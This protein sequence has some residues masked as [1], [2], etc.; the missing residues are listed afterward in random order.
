MQVRA[1]QHHHQQQ[2]HQQQQQQLFQ[3]PLQQLQHQHHSQQLQTHNQHHQQLGFPAAAAAAAAASDPPPPLLQ[4]LANPAPTSPGQLQVA[5]VLPMHDGIVT[6]PG[7]NSQPSQA[8]SDAGADAGTSVGRVT[9]AV[10]PSGVQHGRACM[11]A[12][13]SLL[14]ARQPPPP[15]TAGAAPASLHA[16]LPASGHAPAVC[17]TALPAG[18]QHLPPASLSTVVTVAAGGPVESDGVRVVQAG[19]KPVRVPGSRE[20]QLGPYHDLASM[21]GPRKVSGQ[22]RRFFEPTMVVVFDEG[23]RLADGRIYVPLPFISKNFEGEAFP[24]LLNA[25]VLMDGAV[26]KQEYQV[27]IARSQN[28][29]RRHGL[30]NHW[31]TGHQRLIKNYKDVRLMKMELLSAKGPLVLELVSSGLWEEGGAGRAQLSAAAAAA[32]S[33]AALAASL[34]QGSTHHHHHQQQQQ[35]QHLQQHQQQPLQQHLHLQ[36]QQHHQLQHQIQLHLQQQQQIYASPSGL[37]LNSFMQVTNPAT[38]GGGP[39]SAAALHNLSVQLATGLGHPG[40]NLGSDVMMSLSLNSSEAPHGSLGFQQQYTGLLDSYGMAQQQQQRQQLLLMA[41]LR[42]ADTPAPS[43]PIPTSQLS[44]SLAAPS[45]SLELLAGPSPGVHSSG[46]PHPDAAPCPQLF[47]PLTSFTDALTRTAAMTAP[48]QLPPTHAGSDPCA[49]TLVEHPQQPQQQHVQQQ[50][51]QQ[52]QHVQ[53]PQQQQQQHVQQQ[54]QQQQQQQQPQH[55]T[56]LGAAPHTLTSESLPAAAEQVATPWPPSSSH[57]AAGAPHAAAT[58]EVHTQQKQAPPQ[59]L[60]HLHQQLE[61]LRQQQQQQQHQQQQQ[62]QHHQQQQAQQQHHQ[63]QQAQQQHHQQQTQQQQQQLSY[64]MLPSHNMNPTNHVLQPQGGILPPLS[65]AAPPACLYGSPWSAPSLPGHSSTTA[66]ATL[67]PNNSCGQ[68]GEMQPSPFGAGNTLQSELHVTLGRMTE[69]Q[70]SLSLSSAA[71]PQHWIHPLWNLLVPGSA[72]VPAPFQ[73]QQHPFGDAGAGSGSSTASAAAA[74][75]LTAQAFTFPNPGLDGGLKADALPSLLQL[76]QQPGPHDHMLPGGALGHHRTVHTPPAPAPTS[77]PRLY[78][79]RV[80]VPLNLIHEHF[81]DAEFPAPVNTT[82]FINDVCV[83][84]SI[85][86]R[87]VRYKKHKRPDHFNFWVTGLQ[88]TLAKYNDVRHAGVAWEAGNT[89]RISLL[90]VL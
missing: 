63:Q 88:K 38:T 28:K 14:Q 49:P 1:M 45:S 69:G 37:L 81:P 39:M 23:M 12:G 65:S 27:K 73:I 84:Q 3:H 18:G 31:V 42:N 26:L 79:G 29:T 56:H 61:Q 54:V 21:A 43:D 32:A 44:D 57:A 66:A 82:V 83:G 9:A 36:Q 64:P 89:L 17:S 16:L 19:G 58:D 40:S 80:H 86:A 90:A 10:G 30:G 50:Q 5:S 24:V 6:G 77:N 71:P 7:S 62:Q 4:H 72:G 8:S 53:Q 68:A 78:D 67:F 22:S 47:S 34:A 85:P 33:A 11:E 60:L 75:A 35:P 74:A 87:I 59:E 2:P 46:V 70:L 76:I 41:I 25:T 20:G 48:P 52:Q 15:S 51:Q 55:G 13:G